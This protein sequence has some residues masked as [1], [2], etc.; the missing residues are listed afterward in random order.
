MP[1]WQH[2]VGELLRYIVWIRKS[3]PIPYPTEILVFDLRVL[4]V[5]IT[6]PV[7]LLFNALLS[8]FLLKA[9]LQWNFIF[10]CPGM[11]LDKNLGLG[12]LGE[13]GKQEMDLRNFRIE[14]VTT[15][16]FWWLDGSFRALTRWLGTASHLVCEVGNV[17]SLRGEETWFV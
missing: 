13:F 15:N 14:S 11:C 2:N 6:Y 7:H 5:I 1:G 17:P 10:L 16:L 8:C 4:P 3:F 12:E 9:E